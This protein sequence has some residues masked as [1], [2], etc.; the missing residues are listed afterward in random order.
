MSTLL[1]QIIDKGNL[2]AADQKMEINELWRLCTKLR[3]S[4]VMARYSDFSHPPTPPETSTV[5]QAET[6]DWARDMTP[7]QL[8]EV[9][10]LLNGDGLLN[11][12]EFANTSLDLEGFNP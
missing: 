6:S 4:P 9:V 3:T 11:W 2:I 7:S 5:E 12:V 1:D 8:L 10:D